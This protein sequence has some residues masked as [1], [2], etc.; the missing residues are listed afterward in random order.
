MWIWHCSVPVD[1][2]INL[3]SET[4]LLFFLLLVSLGDVVPWEQIKPSKNILYETCKPEK[5][6]KCNDFDE[7]SIISYEDSKFKKND[8]DK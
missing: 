3:Y 8:R 2:L 5:W 7:K 6:F 1:T 4:W